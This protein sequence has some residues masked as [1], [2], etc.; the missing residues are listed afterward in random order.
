M[1]TGFLIFLL[2][3]IGLLAMPLTMSYRLSWK[4]SFS[5]DLKL[6]WAFGLVQTEASSDTAKLQTGDAEVPEQKSGRSKRSSGRKANVLAALRERSFR[7][8]IVQFFSDVWLAVRKTNVRLLV[9]LGMGDPADTGQLWSIVGPL[10]GML[11]GVSG[12]TIAM[13][14]EF[15]ESTFELDSSGTIRLVPLQLAYVALA[16]LLSPAFWR[17]AILMRTPG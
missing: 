14:P 12:V 6:S 9:R 17:G 10:T 1:L 11:A 7:R 5:G 2:L 3:V 8:R 15:I 13:E 16:L 4:Q